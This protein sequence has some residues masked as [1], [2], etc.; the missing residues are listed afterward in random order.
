MQSSDEEDM[1][2]EM[3]VAKML[4]RFSGGSRLD[5]EQE[6][7]LRAQLAMPKVTSDAEQHQQMVVQYEQVRAKNW[8][9][10]FQEFLKTL[11]PDPFKGKGLK[12]EF[13][14]KK[15]L[16]RTMTLANDD[17]ALV[18]EATGRE[19]AALTFA[20]KG[21]YNS[22]MGII[23][24]ADAFVSSARD[25]VTA[26]SRNA[27]AADDGGASPPDSVSA[28]LISAQEALDRATQARAMLQAP[29]QFLKAAIRGTDDK[30]LDNPS[31]TEAQ[32]L[33][34]AADAQVKH[35]CSKLYE[36]QGKKLFQNRVD[37]FAL[38][39]TAVY[40][41]TAAQHWES[42]TALAVTKL[43][44][45]QDEFRYKCDALALRF[46]T[47]DAALQARRAARAAVGTA[48]TVAP[49][50]PTKP[51]RIA[52]NISVKEL[53]QALSLKMGEDGAGQKRKAKKQ[54]TS[55]KPSASTALE[56][57]LGHAVNA[58]DEDS[59]GEADGE[60]ESLRMRKLQVT[61]I[62]YG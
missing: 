16:H 37:M 27:P 29:S 6:G 41:K 39:L 3:V 52:D 31:P 44:A 19:L 50:A 43:L 47:L 8:A 20:H 61:I 42:T 11:G 5:E 40:G 17:S 2:P 46:C 22:G 58:S 7:Y 56:I 4:S 38:L 30:W 1:P 55:K 14:A 26:N 13:K 23:K 45:E 35:V 62:R 32:I 36:K 33:A 51:K 59:S 34:A 54:K 60:P 48:P 53:H 25:I 15:E 18:H 57:D 28:A 10:K 49:R 24:K 9:S 21:V 12:H